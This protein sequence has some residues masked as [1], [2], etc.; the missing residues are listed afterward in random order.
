MATLPLFLPPCHCPAR[1]R[2]N[3]PRQDRP[4]T[5]KT[6]PFF[7]TGAAAHVERLIDSTAAETATDRLARRGGAP[8][9]SPE[10]LCRCS[11]PKLTSFLPLCSMPATR[12]FRR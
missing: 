3:G 2:K 12:A 9:S 8:V 4:S 6:E 5:P 10:L 11:Q 1:G 7:L